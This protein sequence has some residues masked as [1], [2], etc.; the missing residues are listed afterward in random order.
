MAE[1]I[2][3]GLWESDEQVGVQINVLVFQLSYVF[4]AVCALVP[5]HGLEFI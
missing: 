4:S 3:R 5:E 1:R 2:C